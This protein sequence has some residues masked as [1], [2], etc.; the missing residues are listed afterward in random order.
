MASLPSTSLDDLRSRPAAELVREINENLVRLNSPVAEWRKP[1]HALQAQLLV[2]ELT[3]RDLEAA[4]KEQ[5]RQAKIMV[6]CTVIITVL[7]V[8]MAILTAVM[9]WM[10]AFPPS[11]YLR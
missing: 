8:V 3:R 6:N 7:T 2:Q 10:T 4:G 5:R 1:H 9:A 11:S